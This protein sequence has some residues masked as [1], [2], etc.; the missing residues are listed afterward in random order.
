MEALGGI[1][2]LLTPRIYYLV[3][4]PAPDNKMTTFP[5]RVFEL[6][7]SVHNNNPGDWYLDYG[8]VG[9]RSNQPVTPGGT[10]F[11]LVHPSNVIK[12]TKQTYT[13]VWE[14]GKFR[15]DFDL[16]YEKNNVHQWGAPIVSIPKNNLIGKPALAPTRSGY[17]FI[18]LYKE[19]SCVNAWNF[20]SDRV[21]TDTILY[22]KWVK[23]TEPG[24]GSDSGGDSS[25]GGGGGNVVGGQDNTNNPKVENEN[26]KA[27]KK[28]NKED[29]TKNKK[30]PDNIV[31][32]EPGEGESE[33]NEAGITTPDDGPSATIPPPV[34]PGPP[35]EKPALPDYWSLFDLIMT[36]IAIV[37]AICAIIVE[38]I[39]GNKAR[40]NAS[41]Y[42]ETD[43]EAGMR[44]EKLAP[45]LICAVAAVVLIALFLFTQDT[46]IEMRIFDSWSVIFGVVGIVGVVIALFS[47]IHES[48]YDKN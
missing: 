4:N 13:A 24:G 1:E 9:W 10:D 23:N 6:G 11:E 44:R 5:R 37:A 7:G 43:D 25:G 41:S 12:S 26:K 14:K 34:I 45:L 30:R 3:T 22:A 48:N 16:Q 17:K 39:R 38:L 8:F 36:I 35:V 15:V 20:D 21:V 32:Q 31:E 33:K 42:G 47:I 46:D 29:V 19:A 2:R 28:D 40:S 18:G 27:E